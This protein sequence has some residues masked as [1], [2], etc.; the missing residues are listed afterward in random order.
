MGRIVLLCT[1][2]SNLQ[3]A[4]GVGAERR[5]DWHLSHQSRAE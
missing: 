1:C 2:T 4:E 3:I 5:L